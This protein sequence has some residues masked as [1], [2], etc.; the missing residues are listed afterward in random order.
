MATVALGISANFISEDCST[1]PATIASQIIGRA[2]RA[3][4]P[5]DCKVNPPVAKVPN[6]L[7]PDQFSIAAFELGSDLTKSSRSL[8]M[9]SFTPLP[10]GAPV[11]SI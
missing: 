5:S 2:L 6:H 10:D 8:S 3:E 7:H 4:P 1:T 9:S 11:L